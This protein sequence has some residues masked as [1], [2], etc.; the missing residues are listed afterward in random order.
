MYAIICVKD[1][2]N[3]HNLLP[4]PCL[5]MT[6]PGYSPPW[7]RINCDGDISTLT[8]LRYIP[9]IVSKNSILC[10]FMNPGLQLAQWTYLFITKF[11][12]ENNVNINYI[13]LKKYANPAL[14]LTDDHF[15]SL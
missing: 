6:Q 5:V 1:M 8:F 3:F 7:A 13:Q 14:M 10:C 11:S 9:G 15:K 12:H 4:T 2:D